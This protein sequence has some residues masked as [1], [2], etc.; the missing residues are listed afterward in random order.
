[1]RQGIPDMAGLGNNKGRLRLRHAMRVRDQQRRSAILSSVV[2]EAAERRAARTAERTLVSPARV[3]LY[4]TTFSEDSP[5]P[6]KEI[7]AVAVGRGLQQR[8]TM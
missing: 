2:K 8:A 7:D 5:T 1:M 4:L 3:E 6:R